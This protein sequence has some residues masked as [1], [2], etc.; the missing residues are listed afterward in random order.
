MKD[1]T[2]NICWLKPMILALVI[3]TI[4]GS[5]FFIFQGDSIAESAI[6]IDDIEYQLEIDKHQQLLSSIANSDIAINEF[7]TDGCS[8]GLTIG[9]QKLGQQFPV[10]A[11]Q[12]GDIPPWQTC[13]IIHDQ[14]YHG[15]SVLFS[16]VDDSF[17]ARK[18]ADLELK[19]CVLNTG[20]ERMS[21]LRKTYDLTE[22]KVSAGYQ[23]ISELMYLAVRLGGVPCSNHPWRWGY[24]WPLCQ[25]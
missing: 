12:H 3:I 15:G 11:L 5:I 23:L 1:K 4:I 25:L 10:L 17:N 13:C 21:Y 9:W 2:N 18:Q 22:N 16:S 20:L 6:N 8:G 7:T 24:G 14:K 19:Q